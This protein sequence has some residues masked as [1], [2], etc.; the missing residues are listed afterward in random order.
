MDELALEELRGALDG[1]SSM[2][3]HSESRQPRTAGPQ[4]L[5]RNRVSQTR[6]SRQV[7]KL[8][9]CRRIKANDRE[10]NRMH[11]LNEALDRLRCVLP[12]FPE[13]TKLTKIE[14]LRFA[15]NYIWAL[16]QAV[17]TVRDGGAPPETPI[18]LSVGSVTVTVGGDAGNMITS[19]TGSCAI[20]QQR[21]TGHQY[22]PY[23][24]CS[25]SDAAPTPHYGS[26]CKSDA[27]SAPHYGSP[28]KSDAGSAP[29]YGS[30]CKSDG[31]PTPL[32]GSPCKS[33]PGS[34][35]LYGSPCKLD[36]DAMSQYGSPR[37]ADGGPAPHY[38]SPFSGL[39]LSPCRQ[40]AASTSHGT[41][42]PP[43]TPQHSQY[44][45]EASL[46][47]GDFGAQG[48]HQQHPLQ[49]H[50]QHGLQHG[51]PHG[52]QRFNNHPAMLFNRGGMQRTAVLR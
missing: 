3:G 45:P 24:A 50:G 15:H 26:P 17:Q 19:T 51:L 20:A 43:T 47:F 42:T 1:S 8:K 33:D 25:P 16:S 35:P 27:G 31:V 13:D 52:L 29:H 41:P 7:A 28:C 10:R 6:T 2:S 34:T 9:R 12:T 23:G 32:Y 11:L 18:T 46:L 30:P 39:S 14:T 49:Q 38:G 40:P 48:Y 44:S 37:A 4:T 21:R 5:S 36:G 22:L